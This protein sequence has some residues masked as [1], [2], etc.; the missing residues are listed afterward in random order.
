MQRPQLQTIAPVLSCFYP[1][2]SFSTSCLYHS[3]L[4]IFYM[5]VFP[6]CF[7]AVIAINNQV[8]VHWCGMPWLTKLLISACQA[9]MEHCM[10]SPW[11]QQ[12]TRH[13]P[14][15]NGFM[16]RV[17]RQTHSI[18]YAGKYVSVGTSPR[19]CVRAQEDFKSSAWGVSAD[20]G[21]SI[22]RDDA[23]RKL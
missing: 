7:M 9:C 21:G 4:L 20:T 2:L 18:Q 5:Q 15:P 8:I 16:L 3:E 14:V 12:G 1:M 11:V 22:G 19:K 23:N 13:S 17:R 10:F 6:C